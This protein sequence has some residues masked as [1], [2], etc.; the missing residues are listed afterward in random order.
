MRKERREY[1]FVFVYR[2]IARCVLTKRYVNKV[3]DA[4]FLLCPLEQQRLH[5]KTVQI[6]C[7]TWGVV[8][9]IFAVLFFRR[10]GIYTFV[11]SCMVS[12]ITSGEVLRFTMKRL[13][14]RILRQM[15][16][17][18][19][20]VRHCYYDTHSIGVALQEA[21]MMSG[22]EMRI[23]IDM[24]LSVLSAENVELAVEE[25]NRISG[26]RFLKLF[27]SQCV[28]I[29]EYGDTKRN[30]ESVFVRNLSDL[31]EDILN[32]LLQLGYLQMEF[33]GLTVITLIPILTLPLIRSTAIA[34]L[35]ELGGFYIGTSGIVLPVIYLVVTMLV[36]S[37]ILEMQELDVKNKSRF[38]F[39][40]KLG[41]IR[42][43][44][45]LL[46]FWER[47]HCGRVMCKKR[48]LQ[49][50]G[51]HISP[52]C[53]FLEKILYFSLTEI[54]GTVV[55]VCAKRNVECLKFYEL[56]IL[57][58]LGLIAYLIP[59]A[60]LKYRTALMQM[61]MLSEVTLFQS[62]I[63]MQMFIPDITVLRMLL[64][65]EQFAIIFRKSIQ[66]CINEYSYSVFHALS[67]MK[68][69]ESYEPFRRLCD[70]LLTVDKI[71]IIR[72]FEEVIQDREHFQ[73]Q[74][75]ADTYRMIR[76]KSGQAK[77]IAFVPMLMI[78]VTY[79]IL[80]YGMEAMRQFGE[81]M[82]ELK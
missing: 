3:R 60:R 47:R 55:L 19:N 10:P 22:Y 72:S 44:A 67:N 33:A 58:L 68:A 35:P 26:N 28:A 13:E 46:D 45:T 53:F 61:N 23:H 81:I 52:R 51:E 74:R 18:L 17:L 54:V 49:R 5:K 64:T 71:G 7:V 1:G 59:E 65:M 4:L 32:Y 11:L 34:T 80:P 6:C 37:M 63:I 36:Y 15:E 78:M 31:R 77:L 2:L 30:G 66:E 76:K 40:Q 39:L 82:S 79:L 29:Q 9:L 24:L 48:S 43:I 27:L 38:L 25:Y 12:I 16:K 70:N 75:E 56:C 73:R 62:I 20:D 8:G 42:C 14:R 21:A 50:A 57:L 69:A 41:E